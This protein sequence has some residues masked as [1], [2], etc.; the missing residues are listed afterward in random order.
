M[1]NNRLNLLISVVCVAKAWLLLSA[2]AFSKASVCDPYW[3]KKT[4]NNK[5]MKSK[6]NQNNHWDK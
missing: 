4:I 1:S 2:P 3:K 6:I 5:V